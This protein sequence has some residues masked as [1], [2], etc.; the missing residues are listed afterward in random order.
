MSSSNKQQ[1]VADDVELALQ[2][3]SLLTPEKMPRSSSSDDDETERTETSFDSLEMDDEDD[4]FKPAPTNAVAPS[5]NMSK[6]I[7]ACSLYSFCSVSM[8]LVN[9]SLASSYADETQGNLNILLV[10]F[11]A[12]IAVISVEACR[13]LNWIDYNPVISKE[14]VKQWL[15]VNL[16]FCLMLGSSM[17]ALQTNTVPMVTVFKNVTN[18]FT[19]TGDWFFFG[20]KPECLVWAAFG[21]MLTGAVAASVNDLNMTATGLAWMGVNC[22][23]TAAYVLYLKH[24]TTSIQLS[25]FGMVYVNNVLCMCLLLPVASKFGA[26]VE[27]NPKFLCRSD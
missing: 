4:T 19:T 2:S 12:I 7:S 13:R 26:K 23:S 9:K 16:L 20:N 25:K 10:V 18:I 6:A 3:L 8:I 14:L 17:A 5:S 27:V 24:A 22:V 1:D 11:Q 21:V 15:P